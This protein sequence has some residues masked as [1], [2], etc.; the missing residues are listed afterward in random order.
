[1][2]DSPN[3]RILVN[4]GVGAH[5]NGDRDGD[6]DGGGDGLGVGVEIGNGNDRDARGG[7]S[8]RHEFALVNPRNININTFIGRNLHTNPYIPLNNDRRR[9][10]LAQGQY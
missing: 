1:M 5:G 2:G 9:F 10:I 3:D 4:L 6:R 8:R 7:G